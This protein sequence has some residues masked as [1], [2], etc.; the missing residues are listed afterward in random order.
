MCFCFNR[1]LT[2]VD[3]SPT[4]QPAPESVD[5]SKPLW[6]L[7]A[8]PNMHTAQWPVWDL[9]GGL[10]KVQFSKST[11]ARKSQIHAYTARGSAQGFIITSK[12]T[13]PNPSSPQWPQNL[14]IAWVAPLLVLQLHTSHNCVD[15]GPMVGGE[16]TGCQGLAPPSGNTFL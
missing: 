8:T 7:L 6:H 2:W 4:F 9:R 14:L 11:A 13:F 12:V 15:P 3:S 5:F 10:P 16:R 1:Q